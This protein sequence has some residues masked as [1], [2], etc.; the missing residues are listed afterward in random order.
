MGGAGLYRFE[1]LGSLMRTKG[2]VSRG[3]LLFLWQ[4]L[5]AQIAK[6]GL[7]VGNMG[8]LV[9]LCM[10]MRMARFLSQNLMLV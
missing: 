2:V 1:T 3:I 8:I 9:C 10:M 5:L 7:F 4:C 6:G